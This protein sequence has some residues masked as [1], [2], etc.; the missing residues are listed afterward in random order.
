M[1]ARITRNA[2]VVGVGAVPVYLLVRDVMKA[3]KVQ[4][5]VLNVFLTGVVAY[6]AAEYSG[7]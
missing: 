1:D 7:F 3:L 6:E 2:L 5:D 4:N